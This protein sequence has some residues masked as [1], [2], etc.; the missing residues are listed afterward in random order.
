ML[1]ISDTVTIFR[2]GR[3][4]VSEAADRIDKAWVIERMI[5]RGHEDLEE[6]YTGAIALDSKPDAPVVL[7]VRGLGAGRAFADVSLDVRAGEMLGVYGFMGCGQIE[8][9]RTLFG[10]LKSTAGTL[11]S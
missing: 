11:T 8:L 10:K 9:A 3:R 2:N 6:S 5:G 7:A 1:A 4:I